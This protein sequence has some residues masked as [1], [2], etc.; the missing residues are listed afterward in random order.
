ETCDLAPKR[1]SC[2][3]I[4][5]EG[6]EYHLNYMNR[7]GALDK[8]KS[9]WQA[10]GCLQEVMNSIGVR[11]QLV[12]IEHP[13]NATKGTDVPMVVRLKNIGWS[14]IHNPRGFRVRLVRDGSGEVVERNIAAVD[15][16]SWQPVRADAA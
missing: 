13:A 11:I 12:D 6:R 5:T 15:P 7:Y 8:F 3:A 14:R 10:E 9:Q 1:T 16:R 4:R 2:S